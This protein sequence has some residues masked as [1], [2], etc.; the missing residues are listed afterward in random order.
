MAIVD[1][2][3]RV[4]P[5]LGPPAPHG[6]PTTHTPPAPRSRRRPPISRDGLPRWV[7]QLPYA[8]VLCGVALGL[9]V[10][11]IGHFKKGS[12]LVGAAVLFGA[13]ARLV[14][15][16]GQVGLLATRKRAIDVLILVGFAVAITAVAYAVRP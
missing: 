1:P 8:F 2:Q 5:D 12:L 15:P 11:A 14:L 4:S 13:L 7:R 9:A 16:A 6:P 10:V 3:R